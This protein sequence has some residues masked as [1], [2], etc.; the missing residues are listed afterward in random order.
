MISVL[1]V[2]AGNICRSPMADAVFQQRVREAGLDSQIRVDSA[3][4]GSWNVGDPPHPET[5]ALLREN[6]I[7][8]EGVARQIRYADLERFDYVLA[9]DRENLSDILR[10]LNRGE[11]SAQQKL[12]LFYD[13]VKKPEIALFLS[14]ANRAGTV[15]LWALRSGL[16]S[17]GSRVYGAAGSS[18]HPARTVISSLQARIYNRLYWVVDRR[19]TAF[20]AAWQYCPL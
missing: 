17:G 14:Y 4:T 8:Y 5:R 1:F 16:Q 12:D 2:C 9:M 19:L 10:L 18:P 13:G 3:G 11:R 6:D 7:P 20:G 15:L